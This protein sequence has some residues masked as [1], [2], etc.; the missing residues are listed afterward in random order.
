MSAF[1]ARVVE[2]ALAG[3]LGPSGAN[4]GAAH[5]DAVTG[6]VLALDPNVGDGAL[7]LGHRPPQIQ[8]NLAEN[9][10]QTQMGVGA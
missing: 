6:S 7:A 4:L 9:G 5:Q 2:L 3:A 8:L 10:M 1:E